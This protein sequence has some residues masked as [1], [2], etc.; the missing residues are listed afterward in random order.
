MNDEQI[1]FLGYGDV[2]IDTFI[3]LIDAW[4]ET[5]NPEEKQELVNASQQQ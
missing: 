4:I 1:D 3:E 2:V 5:D